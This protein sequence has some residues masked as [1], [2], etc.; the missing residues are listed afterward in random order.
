MKPER[1]L[2]A[3]LVSSGGILAPTEAQLKIFEQLGADLERGSSRALQLALAPK[4]QPPPTEEQIKQREAS[5]FS[6]NDS[7]ALA[8]V[9]RSWS[10]LAISEAEVAKIKVPTIAIIGGADPLNVEAVNKLKSAMPMLKVVLLEKATHRTAMEQP[11]SI[12][13]LEDF[14]KANAIKK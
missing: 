13:A 6:D 1:F 14:L 7:A 12:G 2:P 8:A 4:D 3:T 5:F 10:D 11:E 9:A